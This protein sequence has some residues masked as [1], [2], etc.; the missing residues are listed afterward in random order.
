[1]R[2]S[3]VMFSTTRSVYRARKGVSFYLSA[4]SFLVFLY[5]NYI[6]FSSLTDSLLY[7]DLFKS[8]GHFILDSDPRWHKEINVIRGQKDWMSSHD[9]CPVQQNPK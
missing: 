3:L 4:F 8:N 1:M 7:F 2:V 9:R 5:T 6:C